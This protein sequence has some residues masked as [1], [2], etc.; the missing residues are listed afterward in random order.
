MAERGVR[1]RNGV[2]CK[3]K[4]ERMVMNEMEKSVNETNDQKLLI[5]PRKHQP[6]LSVP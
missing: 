1:Q 6:T 5:K 3:V 2:A 4:T